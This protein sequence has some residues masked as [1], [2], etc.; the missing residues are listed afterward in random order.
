MRA[1]TEVCPYIL[2]PPCYLYMLAEIMNESARTDG[3][4]AME[5]LLHGFLIALRRCRKK[6]VDLDRSEIHALCLSTLSV[7]GGGAPAVLLLATREGEFRLE[8]SSGPMPGEADKLHMQLSPEELQQLGRKPDR[9]G[10][11]AGYREMCQNAFGKQDVFGRALVSSKGVT[12]TLLVLPPEDREHTPEEIE[13]LRLVAAQINTLLMTA[14]EFAVLVNLAMVDD[15]T[16]LYNHRY[17][18]KRLSAEISRATRHGHP[19][20]LLFCEIDDYE[21][22]SK[23][24]GRPAADLLLSQLGDLLKSR[25]EIPGASFCFRASDVPIR[26]GG[27]DFVVLLPETPKE[28]A[29]TK[30]ERLRRFV[31][32]SHIEGGENQ[33]LGRV[34]ISIGLATYPDDASDAVSLLGAAD[35]ALIQAKE[36][37]KN[38]VQVV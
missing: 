37:G 7:L 20:S 30:A 15:Q 4:R 16:G 9:L 32:S 3:Y 6:F 27:E 33:P 8:L 25:A 34:T 29:L 28:G 35:R 38:R 11:L 22:F 17:L 36:Q 5:Q 24:A 1:H 31:E 26:Y 10:Q 19:L 23:N 14:D 21:T 2:H 18:D 13:V 12:G